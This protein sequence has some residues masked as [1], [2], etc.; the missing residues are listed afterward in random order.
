M[1]TF[2]RGD[3]LE[4]ISGALEV[5]MS[6]LRRLT[7]EQIEQALQIEETLKE[8]EEKFARL[9]G[10]S[11][12]VVTLTSA[13]N[14]RYIEVNESF[15]RTMGWRRDEVIGRTPYDLGIWVDR[16]QRAELVRRL[17]SEQLFEILRFAFA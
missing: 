7:R 13:K 8:S 2:K 11:P 6:S 10:A 1:R 3:P 17:L 5:F 15:E 16:G 12:L 4:K 9:F 14:D